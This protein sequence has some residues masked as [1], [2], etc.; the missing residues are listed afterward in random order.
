M[1]WFHGGV[2]GL[3]EGDFLSPSPPH[4]TDGCPVCVARAEGRSVSVGQFRSWV[5]QFGERARP[6]LQA[7]EGAPADAPVDP[8]SAREGIYITTHEGY[9]AWYAARSG[10]GDLYEIAPIGDVVWSD[11]DHFPSATVVKARIVRVLRRSVQLT[12]HERRALSREWE[13]RDR[14]V[15]RR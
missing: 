13:K 11:S 8:P 4:V 9:A 12:R 2:A 15:G 1:S 6:V 3:R 5:A 7:L 14:N 10:N